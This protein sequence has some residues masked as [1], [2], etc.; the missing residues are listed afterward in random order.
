MSSNDKASDYFLLGGTLAFLPWVIVASPI[1]VPISLVGCVCN[2]FTG[3]KSK[4]IVIEHEITEE[5]IEEL[6]R[7]FECNKIL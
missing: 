6:V 5:Q 1:I 3:E 4:V 7:V 2:H